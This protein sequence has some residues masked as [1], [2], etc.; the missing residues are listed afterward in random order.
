MLRGQRVPL[1]ANFTAG[2]G[3][4]LARAKFNKQS[5]RSLLGREGGI[6]RPHVYLMQPYDPNRRI[7]VMLH[8]LASSPEAWVELA[9][10]ILGDEALR[11]HYQI[12][13]VYYPTNMP[14]ALNHAMIRR[15]LGDTLAHFDPSGQAPASSDLVLVGH[16]MGGVI[17]RLMVSSTDQSLVQLA[18]DRSRLTPQQIKRIDPMLRFEPFPNVSSA[19]FIAAPHRGTSVA[20]GRLG[21]W[22]A[23]FIRFPITVLEELAH[24]LTPNAAASSRESLATIPNSVNNLDENDPFVRTAA[25]FPISS[26]VRYHSIV[27]QANSEVA[28]D[29]S[30]DGLVPYRSAHLPGAQ[31]EKVIISGHSVQ[32]SAAAILE[33]QRILREDMALRE[34]HLQP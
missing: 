2:Y 11:Q 9:N 32:Q 30:D 21:R 28:L 1:A 23:G 22:M 31:S 18:A 33:I 14:I 19:I 16:S 17:A 3:V 10:E 6:D 27:A 29:D 15:A 8:G 25:G 34:A 7:I 24:T 13:Q 20:G 5:L 4:W 12:W 26:Q